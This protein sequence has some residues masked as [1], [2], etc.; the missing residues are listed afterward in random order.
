MWTKIIQT[1]LNTSFQIR[2]VGSDVI[3]LYKTTELWPWLL[4]TKFKQETGWIVHFYGFHN[5]KNF[6]NH[7][8]L[9][10]SKGRNKSPQS[11]R[12]AFLLCD[13]HHS[14]PLTLNRKSDFLW[15][16]YAAPTVWGERQWNGRVLL[17][18][19]LM[20]VPKFKFIKHTSNLMSVTYLDDTQSTLGSWCQFLN[21]QPF[22]WPPHPFL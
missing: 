5:Q 4:L 15:L 22:E 18:L 21:I 9:I 6:L 2:T 10:F 8:G 20:S 17:V 3:C 13:S 16:S 14:P 1:E 11:T 7:S 19:I 12:L